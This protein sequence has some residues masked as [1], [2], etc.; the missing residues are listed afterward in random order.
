MNA[1]QKAGSIEKYIT[2][3]LGGIGVKSSEDRGDAEID[4]KFYEIKTST[5]NKNQ[6]LNIRQ[7]RLYQDIDFYICSY[8]DERCLK[9]SKTY[10]L[11]KDEMAAEVDLIGGFTHGTVSSNIGKINPEYSITLPVMNLTNKH[12]KRWNKHYWYND[13]YSILQGKRTVMRDSLDRFYTKSNVA[14]RC[15]DAVLEIT[16]DYDLIIEPSAGSGAFSKHLPKNYAFDIFPTDDS[17]IE[18]DWLSVEKSYFSDYEKLLVIGNPPFGT[19]SSLAKKFISHS[20]NNLNACTIAFLLPKTFNKLTSQNV[21][22]ENWRLIKIL[23]LSKNDSTFNLYENN[24]FFIP[25]DFFIWTS[26][27]D[28]LQGED[29]RKRKNSI[30][31]EIVFMPRGSAD[32]DFTINGNNGKIKEISDVTNSK[33]EHYIKVNPLYDKDEIKGF[34]NN[35]KYDFHSSVN[36]GVAWINKDDIAYTFNEAKK[37]NKTVFEKL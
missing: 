26:R 5:T 19:R 22:P 2:A 13:L 33:A 10:L 30:P 17:I 6:C 21:F 8:I 3:K 23:E 25:C 28:L 35:L 11:S 14:K 1:Q 32:A 20:I 24:D 16:D 4:G 36:G 12:V 31:E 29:L 27:D 18:K 34:L 7:I 9:N 37:N 15:I